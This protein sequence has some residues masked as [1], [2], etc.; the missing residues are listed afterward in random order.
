MTAGTPVGWKAVSQRTTVIIAN[1]SHI[2]LL[3]SSRMAVM[4]TLP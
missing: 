3:V 2:G 1:R 4:T